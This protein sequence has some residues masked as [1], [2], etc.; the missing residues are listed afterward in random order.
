MTKNSGKVITKF[1][2]PYMHSSKGKQSQLEHIFT[3]SKA[4]KERN[5]EN[6]SQIDE[7]EKKSISKNR[8][9]NQ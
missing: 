3:V 4:L 2:C 6:R 9:I 8:Q 5:S 7:P 1:R